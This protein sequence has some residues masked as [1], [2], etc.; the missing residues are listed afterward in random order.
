MPTLNIQKF[1]WIDFKLRNILISLRPWSLPVSLVP[2]FLSGIIIMLKNL[3]TIVSFNFILC[4]LIT[5]TAHCFANITNTYFDFVNKVDKKQSDDRGLI[6]KHID[7]PIIKNVIIGLLL[8]LLFL[9]VVSLMITPTEII[10]KLLIIVLP[11]MFI[12]LFYTSNI[13]SLKYYGYGL[14]EFSLFI[15]F[16]PMIM[17]GVSVLLTGYF[18][19]DVFILSLP[20]GFLTVNILHS[21]NQRDID[22]DILSNIKS[23]AYQLGNNSYNFYKFNFVMSYLIPIIFCLASNN[24]WLNDY[25]IFT[26]LLNLPWTIYLC[27]CFN[28]KIYYELPQKT[29]QHNLLYGF[30]LGASILPLEMFGRLLL[31]LLF[32]LGGINN[33]IMFEYA[34]ALSHEKLSCINKNISKSL[35]KILLL[36]A[37]GGQIS[38][39]TIFILGF[40]PK[41]AIK[42]MI[43]FLTPVT[44]L[45]HNFWI[46]E[47]PSQKEM[48]IN[49]GI[50]TFPSKFDSEFVHFFKNIGMIG[51]CIIY[52][53]YA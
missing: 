36:V 13:F 47:E 20:L 15:L 7:I 6:D 24:I 51:G 49:N 45:V 9:L 48:N 44:F 52:L 50:L 28:N 33:I 10:L 43:A 17:Q 34:H 12:T 27:N 32:L 21:N 37:I 41:I 30:L 42:I 3:G 53:I 38:S 35:S 29:A 31:G 46:I 1:S 26:I 23:L 18:N 16:G 11:C 2:I 39:S 19:R 25:R 22:N 8:F 40:Y 14:P 5:I 4:V